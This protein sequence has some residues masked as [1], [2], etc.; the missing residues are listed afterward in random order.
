M[1]C[2]NI[3]KKKYSKKLIKNVVVYLSI[4][5]LIMSFSFKVNASVNFI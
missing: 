1:N 2:N 3:H 5:I 4:F